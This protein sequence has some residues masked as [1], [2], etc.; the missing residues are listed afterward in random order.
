M[1]AKPF[2]ASKVIAQN[3]N[4]SVSKASP[5]NSVKNITTNHRYPA[6]PINE[7]ITNGFFK[8]DRKWTVSYWNTASEKLLGVKAEDIIG[9]N[10]WEEFASIIP[11][12]L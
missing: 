5:I 2:K 12:E 8:V 9:K 7:T 4:M 10:L 6:T 1:K 3:G 11:L